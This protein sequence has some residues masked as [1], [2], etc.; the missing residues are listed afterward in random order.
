MCTLDEH[1]VV[2][3]YRHQYRAHSKSP[4]LYYVVLPATDERRIREEIRDRGHEIVET[5][6]EDEESVDEWERLV[7]GGCLEVQ[8]EPKKRA[9]DDDLPF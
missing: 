5:Y 7:A 2:I 4:R 6:Q 1:D 8:G 9:S 3:V